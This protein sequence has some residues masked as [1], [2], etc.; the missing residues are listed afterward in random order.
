MKTIEGQQERGFRGAA[1]QYIRASDRLPV[2]TQGDSLALVK[3]FNPCG[4]GSWYLAE[5]DPEEREAFGLCDIQEAELGYVSMAELVSYRGAY[6]LP[7]ERDLHW[8]PRP[9]SQ[10]PGS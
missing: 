2:R 3:L 4:V 6:G 5:Y 8:T 10:C 7:I 9:L 1:Y